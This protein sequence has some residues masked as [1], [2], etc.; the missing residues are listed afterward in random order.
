[1]GPNEAVRQNEEKINSIPKSEKGA[2]EIHKGNGS[3]TKI[4]LWLVFSN[5]V[6]CDLCWENSDEKD[7][8]VKGLYGLFRYKVNSKG[9]RVDNGQRNRCVDLRFRYA[10]LI[11][12]KSL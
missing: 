12:L 11:V 8:S 7:Y 3:V 4:L 10:L 6:L 1:M 2:L 5:L 9:A